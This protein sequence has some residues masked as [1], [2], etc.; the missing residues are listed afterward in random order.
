MASVVCLKYRFLDRDIEAP[1]NLTARSTAP[2]SAVEHD[3][4]LDDGTNTASGKPNWMRYNG[5]SWEDL[6]GNY[7]TAVTTD[8]TLTG[9]GTVADPLSFYKLPNYTTVERDAIATPVAGMEIYNTTDNKP[10]FYNGTEWIAMGIQ[11]LIKVS[12][13]SQAEG[14]NSITGFKNKV[15]IKRIKIET[16]ATNWTLTLYEKDDYSTDPFMA[17]L[18]GNGDKVIYLD[19][20]YEDQDASSEFHYKFTDEIGTATHDIEVRGLE[21]S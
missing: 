18:L 12:D 21:L 7:L 4:Y 19:H 9:V 14:N 3:I 8:T 6:S 17:M 13:T 11:K 1:V 16:T 5:A 15:N 20:L 10:E 2:T